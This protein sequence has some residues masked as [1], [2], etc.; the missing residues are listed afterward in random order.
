MLTLEPNGNISNL[1]SL[2]SSVLA[3]SFKLNTYNQTLSVYNLVFVLTKPTIAD[4][5]EIKAHN[6][7]V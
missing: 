3:F 1:L 7:L 5:Q 2:V 6:P 4:S